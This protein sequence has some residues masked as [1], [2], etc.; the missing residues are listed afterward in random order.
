MLSRPPSPE[1][2]VKIEGELLKRVAEARR[3]C[4]DAENR[5]TSLYQSGADLGWNHPDGT[6]A[7]RQAVRLERQ[8]TERYAQVIQ[9][10]NYFVLEFKVPRDLPE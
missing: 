10:L 4:E 7:F 8:A 5:A 3:D 2:L 6:N 9:R 1:E